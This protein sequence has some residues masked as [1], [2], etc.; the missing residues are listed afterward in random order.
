MTLERM[1]ERNGGGLRLGSAA[2]PIVV[3]VMIGLLGKVF[4][5]VYTYIVSKTQVQANQEQTIRELAEIKRRLDNQYESIN[6]LSNRTIR[7]EDSI[8]NMKQTIGNMQL[9]SV[10]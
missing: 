10:K 9:K 6:Q 8:E 5:A 4:A 3:S 7:V 1:P 2:I